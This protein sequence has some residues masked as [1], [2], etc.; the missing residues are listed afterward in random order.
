LYVVNGLSGTISKLDPDTGAVLATF[1]KPTT[2]GGG[3][4]DAL[5][6][7][8]ASLFY[9]HAHT[10]TI[11]ELDPETGAV[12]N[13]FT[14]PYSTGGLGF[15]L[16][17]FGPTLFLVGPDSVIFLLDPDSGAVLSSFVPEINPPNQVVGIDFGAA[18]GSLFA[19]T[20]VST[21]PRILQLHPMTGAARHF[22]FPGGVAL[23]V[24]LVGS[25][26][27]LSSLSWPTQP[28]GTERI[29]ELDPETGDLLNSIPSPDDSPSALAG[30][31]AGLSLPSC[32]LTFSYSERTLTV[33]FVLR[34]DT[35]ARWNLWYSFGR[36][37]PRLWS[38][39]I[40]PVP[41]EK[42]VELPLREFADLGT[43]GF[44]T[45]LTNENGI[46]CSDW[47]AFDTGPPLPPLP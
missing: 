22:V 17:A 28:P 40:P 4:A 19:G 3:N 16:T 23:G 8:G 31:P 2:G 7:S 10:N 35:Q 24:G 34:T 26:L 45:T 43:V 33:R 44:L 42:P 38:I 6:F 9:T 46:V 47:K 27:F 36:R 18:S 29:I 5:A 32:G 25:R 30:T 39:R 37:A 15:G 41:V 1:P 21:A 20:D 12:K 13:S 11:Y 14:T